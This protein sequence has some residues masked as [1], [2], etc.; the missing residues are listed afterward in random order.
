MILL[1]TM[2]I[3]RGTM[4]KVTNAMKFEYM[5]AGMTIVVEDLMVEADSMEIRITDH[6]DQFSVSRV[7][8]KGT[9]M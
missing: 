9:N 5:S 2:I 1:R 7:I 8:M 4:N 6:D 3:S